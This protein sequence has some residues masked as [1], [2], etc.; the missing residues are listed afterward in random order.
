MSLV[1]LIDKITEREIEQVLE[2]VSSL[3]DEFLSD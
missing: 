3:I 1:V 2:N